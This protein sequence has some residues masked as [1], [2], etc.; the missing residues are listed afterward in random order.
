MQAHASPEQAQE[1]RIQARQLREAAQQA[2]KERQAQISSTHENNRSER[3]KEV[4][5]ER[6]KAAENTPLEQ[7]TQQKVKKLKD[8]QLKA[9]QNRE[10]AI[11]RIMA[12]ISDRGIK[13]LDVLTTASDRVQTYHETHGLAAKNYDALLA[14][15]NTHKVLAEDA[16]A[17]AHQTS[18]AFDCEGDNPKGTAKLF[19]DDLRNQNE[20]LNEYRNA[21]KNLMNAVRSAQSTTA[22]EVRE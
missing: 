22:E 13:Q 2:A 17:T 12:R 21:I 11:Q 3:A 5:A 4:H 7:E 1:A 16:V 10:Q 19:K 15:V 14:T 9:C 18:F 6:D 8:K 20:R